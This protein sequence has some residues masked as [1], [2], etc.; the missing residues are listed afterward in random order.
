MK[1]LRIFPRS[2]LLLALT[3]PVAALAQPQVNRPA[4]AELFQVNPALTATESSA[5]ELKDLAIIRLPDTLILAQIN[6][7]G[8]LAK[9]QEKPFPTGD[10]E[11]LTFERPEGQSPL[12][13]FVDPANTK[14]LKLRL[15]TTELTAQIAA[16]GAVYYCSHEPPH[17]AIGFAEVQRLSEK[18]GCTGW[19]LAGG[20]ANLP[21]AP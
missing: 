4:S 7:H 19:N 13:V 18:Y 15:G 6:E 9:L 1:P 21:P 11:T 17:N 2:F 16:V 14:E 5:A 20:S 3:L 12:T 8:V 10:A